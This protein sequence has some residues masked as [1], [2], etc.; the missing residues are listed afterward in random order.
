MAAVVASQGEDTT[1]SEVEGE[2]AAIVTPQITFPPPG[3]FADVPKTLGAVEAA[4]AFHQYGLVLVKDLLPKELMEKGFQEA[5]ASFEK[6]MAVY[7]ERGIEKKVGTKHGFQEIV[8]RSPGRFEMNYGMDSGVFQDIVKGSSSPQAKFL[9]TFMRHTIGQ[10]WVLRRQSLLISFPGA[11]GMQWHTDGDHVSKSKHL[12]AHYINVFVALRD[13]TIEQGP[14]ELRPASHFLTRDLGKMM[15]LAKIKK[16]LHE[17]VTPEAAQG[18]AVIFRLP[19]A[20]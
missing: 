7:E 8:M 6:L 4:R 17:P 9:D 10:D 14:T 12:P 13:V 20:T 11:E 3:S 15:F 5:M 18:D 16:R 1:P 19:H 2:T